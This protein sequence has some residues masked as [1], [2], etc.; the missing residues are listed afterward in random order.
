[1]WLTIYLCLQIKQLDLSNL[2]L[3]TPPHILFAAS[4]IVSTDHNLKSINLLCG[5][6]QQALAFC[7]H[8]LGC[9]GWGRLEGLD[10]EPGYGGGALDMPDAAGK[11]IDEEGRQDK[12][13]AWGDIG[14]I[15]VGDDA[16]AV[17]VGQDEIVEIGEKA[18]GRGSKKRFY[19]GHPLDGTT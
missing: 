10:D 9:A 6:G 15:V 7:L 13:S 12:G 19:R 3:Q 18:H 16:L 14:A 2:I 4:S 11:A 17:I 1:M 5:P 8:F